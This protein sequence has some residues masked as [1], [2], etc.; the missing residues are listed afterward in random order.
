MAIGNFYYVRAPRKYAPFLLAAPRV[1]PGPI[2]QSAD[3]LR[4]D[5]AVNQGLVIVSIMDT[6]DVMDTYWAEYVAIQGG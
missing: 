1:N 3:M 5:L 4:R 2:G 6:G